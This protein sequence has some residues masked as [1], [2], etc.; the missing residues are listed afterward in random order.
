MSESL[1][2]FALNK[3][4][5]KQGLIHKV[6]LIG[7]GDIGQ[8]VARIVSQSGIEVVFVEVSSERVDEVM[9]AINAQLDAIINRWGLT[10]GDKRIILSRI[11]G[12]TDYEA[13][14]DC[15]LII[16]LISS[17]NPLTERVEMFK[18]LETYV[19]S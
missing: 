12:A 14:R 11:K 1:E 3:R 18:T 8:Q 10:Q 15:N 4:I 13:I 16:E 9:Q 7:C 17:D 5:S 2:K 19:S 6:G